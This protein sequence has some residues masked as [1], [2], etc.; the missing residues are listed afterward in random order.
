MRDSKGCYVATRSTLYIHTR[1]R[2]EKGWGWV[3][4]RVRGKSGCRRRGTSDCLL[5]RTVSR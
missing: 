4:C 5:S 3:D 2:D 1:E